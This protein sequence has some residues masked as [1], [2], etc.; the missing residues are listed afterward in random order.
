MA[1]ASPSPAPVG[2][3]LRSV[4]RSVEAAREACDWIASSWTASSSAAGGSAVRARQAAAPMPK[5]SGLTWSWRSREIRCRSALACRAAAP[6][7]RGARSRAR[8]RRSRRAP[9]HPCGPVADMAGGAV[10]RVEHAD[11]LATE[12]Q[13]RADDAVDALAPH[14]PVDEVLGDVRLDAEVGH[15]D[16]PPGAQHRAADPVAGAHPQA[17]AHLGGAPPPAAAHHQQVRLLADRHRGGVG[18]DDRAELAGDAR[19]DHRGVEQPEDP[20]RRLGEAPQIV[21]REGGVVGDRTPGNA[22]LRRSREGASPPGCP[23]R[24]RPRRRAGAARSG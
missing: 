6:V 4:S 10:D 15:R 22:H 2:A 14:H 12:P 11:H 8:P 16:R 19:G 18:A 17:A 20:P 9:G 21:D 1:A 5:S 3:R 13:R 24:A 7:R 23:A